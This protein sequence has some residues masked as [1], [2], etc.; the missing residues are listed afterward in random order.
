MNGQI[1]AAPIKVDLNSDDQYTQLT[2]PNDLLLMRFQ[3]R[4]FAGG[5]SIDEHDHEPHIHFNELT[6]NHARDLGLIP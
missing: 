4:K 1:D 6:A 3:S 2:A 5:A